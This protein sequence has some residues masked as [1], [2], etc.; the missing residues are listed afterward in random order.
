MAATVAKLRLSPAGLSRGH[1]WRWRLRGAIQLAPSSS[2]TTSTR[3]RI[4]TR[5]SAAARINFSKKGALGKLVPT[6]F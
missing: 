2:P 3:L 4:P 1:H 5:N 6:G